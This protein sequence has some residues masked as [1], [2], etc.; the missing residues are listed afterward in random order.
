MLGTVTVVHVEINDGNF[1]SVMLCWAWR[2]AMATLLKTQNPIARECSAWWPGGGEHK[3]HYWQRRSSPDQPPHTTRLRLVMQL[4]QRPE[5]GSY[6]DQE[7]RILARNTRQN[8]VNIRRIMH[9]VRDSRISFWRLLFPQVPEIAT[10]QD[11]INRF[12]TLG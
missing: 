2:A 12:K 7:K 11:R 1:F 5:R 10:R 3:R 4:H 6:R 8:T 9:M